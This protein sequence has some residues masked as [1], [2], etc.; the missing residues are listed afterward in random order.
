MP[1]HGWKGAQPCLKVRRVLIVS[2]FAQAA[3]EVLYIVWLWT[4]RAP[5]WPHPWCCATG[6]WDVCAC[7]ALPA[8][9][10]QLHSVIC[11]CRLTSVWPAYCMHYDQP[12]RGGTGSSAWV[13]STRW[14][15][16]PC[17]TPAICAVFLCFCWMLRM[18]HH[19]WTL[20]QGIHHFQHLKCFLSSC[21]D[22]LCQQACLC[23][24]PSQ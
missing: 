12:T 5:A 6:E 23:L 24:D 1:A 20:V 17:G 19:N 2:G 4:H 14:E 15:K 3:N 13:W 10:L 16:R 22:L 9:W 7:A 11:M 18:D 21:P 8:V